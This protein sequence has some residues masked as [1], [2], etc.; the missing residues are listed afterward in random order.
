M[1]HYKSVLII[2][3]VC[4][5]LNL[6]YFYDCD[7]EFII[8]FDYMFLFGLKVYLFTRYDWYKSIRCI[9]VRGILPH[10]SQ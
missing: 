1:Y 4:D 3:T 2:G 7:D 6:H 9:S 8:V 5:I 10:D